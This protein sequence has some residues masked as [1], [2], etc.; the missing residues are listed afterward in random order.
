MSIAVFQGSVGREH[1]FSNAHEVTA[2]RGH[3]ALAHSTDGVP[4]GGLIQGFSR[5]P[6]RA[7]DDNS[8]DGLGDGGVLALGSHAM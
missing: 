4:G 5:V 6:S 8:A 3:G 7:R 2:P 1:H